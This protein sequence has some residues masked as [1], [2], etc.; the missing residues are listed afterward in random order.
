M[1]AKRIVNHTEVLPTIDPHSIDGSQHVAGV[2]RV[3]KVRSNARHHLLGRELGV[4]HVRN[5][6]DDVLLV[7][8]QLVTHLLVVVVLNQSTER[9]H[10]LDISICLVGL[11]G[12]VLG[13]R[14]ELVRCR[15]HAGDCFFHE[16]QPEVLCSTGLAVPCPIAV[17]VS[18]ERV[19]A[20]PHGN[21]VGVCHAW[22]LGTLTAYTVLAPKVMPFVFPVFRQ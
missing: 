5:F 10:P 4:G 12:N 21:A 14:H 8:S 1:A 9:C 6:K 3:H 17:A 20:S 16:E 11:L 18:L 15:H 19:H 13:P 22:T 2:Q 7:Y